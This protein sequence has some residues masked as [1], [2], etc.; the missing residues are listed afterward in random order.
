MVLL[1]FIFINGF[2]YDNIDHAYLIGRILA[3]A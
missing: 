1:I 2:D 3:P